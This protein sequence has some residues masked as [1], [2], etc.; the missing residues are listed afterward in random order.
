M[1][2]FGGIPIDLSNLDVDFLVSSSNKCFQG[3]P[4]FSFIIARHRVVGIIFLNSDYSI[5]ERDVIIYPG[6][7]NNKKVFRIGNIGDITLEEIEY[8]LSEIKSYLSI[9]K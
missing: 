8:A 4:G 7:I 2:S 9:H 6:K 5:F 1:S 3:A